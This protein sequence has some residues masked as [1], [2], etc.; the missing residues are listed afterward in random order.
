[1][2]AGVQSVPTRFADRSVIVTIFRRFVYDGGIMGPEDAK[3][4]LDAGA[5]LVQVYTGLVFAGP[6]L[7]KQIVL[8]L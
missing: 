8:N 7:V 6:G 5:A 3:V 1:V 4:R 2:A